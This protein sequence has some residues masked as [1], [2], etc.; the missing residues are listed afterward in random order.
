MSTIEVDQLLAEISPDAPSGENLEYDA[1]YVDLERLAQ[2]RADQQ[3]GDQTIEAQ[4]P[5]WQEVAKRALD[6]LT[7]TKD[8]RV[9]LYL[10]RA[11][12]HTEG[13]PGFS[14]GLEY[15]R[16]LVERY[17]ETV[18]PQV[19]SDDSDDPIMRINAISGLA[20]PTAVLNVVRST[21]LTDS[22][23]FGKISYRDLLVA[24]GEL[25]PAGNSDGEPPDMVRIDGAFSDTDAE[26]L[27][28]LAAAAH[29]SIAHAEAIDAAVTEQVGTASAPNLEELVNLLKGIERILTDR[30]GG[31]APAPESPAAANPAASAA[32]APAHSGD[33]GG[34][35]DVIAALDRICAYYEKNEPS[36][37]VPLL[38]RRAKR[39]VSKNFMEIIGD[40]APDTIKQIEKISGN[41]SG[42]T[43]E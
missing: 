19:D 28:A 41:D 29:D 42:E 17:W 20:D 16:S 10:I 37:P 9:A 27:L 36:S 3:M 2:G 21:P 12:L 5:D 32:A 30:A 39:L 4:P 18:H 14:K 11:Q 7:R 25:P 43:R 1:A 33:I 24:K 26:T 6:L 13:L 31:D 23:T 35:Q 8:L 22:R 40:L 15:L 34:P 38:I